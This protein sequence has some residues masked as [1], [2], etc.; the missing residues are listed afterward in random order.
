MSYVIDLHPVMCGPFPTLDAAKQFV[1]SVKGSPTARLFED[2]EWE[3]RAMVAP[4]YFCEDT[5]RR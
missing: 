3:I 5:A 1:E 4:I 2:G